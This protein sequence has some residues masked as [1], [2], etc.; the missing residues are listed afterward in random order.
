[1]VDVVEV[2]EAGYRIAKIGT[3]GYDTTPDAIAKL[4]EVNLDMMNL[5]TPHYGK[6]Q[7]LDDILGSYVKEFT[8]TFTSG[9]MALPADFYGFIS[10]TKT[11]AGNTIEVR[12]IK[13]N[14]IGAIG[15]NTIRMPTVAKPKYYFSQGNIVLRPS[16][17]DAG[18]AGLYF[19]KPVDVSI[20]TTPVEGDTN[21]YEEVTAQ[22]DFDWP[23]RMKNLLIYLFVERLGQEMKEP[24]LFEIAQL[25][26]QQNM[27]VNSANQPAQPVNNYKR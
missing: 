22:T 2:Q 10:F 18:L 26:I 11:T 8:P 7:A 27:T 13:T 25:G 1:M 24:I 19:R 6:I 14:A 16:N 4:N 3:S 15:Q 5:L 9:L 17:G 12:K 21:D 23:F 20:T